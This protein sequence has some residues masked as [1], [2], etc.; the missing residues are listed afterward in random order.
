LEWGSLDYNGN[1]I[2]L[3]NYFQASIFEN[4]TYCSKKIKIGV[5]LYNHNKTPYD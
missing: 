5:T 2:D 3:N 1:R 4:K